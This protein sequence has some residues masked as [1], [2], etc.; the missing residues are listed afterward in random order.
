[1]LPLV[2]GFAISSDGYFWNCFVREN[3]HLITKEIWTVQIYEA[4]TVD[5]PYNS[6]IRFKTF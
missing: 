3:L 6:G 4:S 1:M 2:G 5:P